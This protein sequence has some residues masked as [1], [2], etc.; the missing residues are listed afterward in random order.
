MTPQ[1]NYYRVTGYTAQGQ[2][3]FGG[4]NQ[5]VG[6]GATFNLDN[7]TPNT[8]LSWFPPLQ[9]LK[10][11]VA[12]SPFSSATLLNFESSDSS[13]MIT[14]EGNGLLN[15]QSAS[16]G[17]VVGH[18][19]F[20]GAGLLLQDIFAYISL[21]NSNP[22]NIEGAGIP[23]N[24]IA[25]FI[26][27]TPFSWTIDSVTIN[28][29]ATMAGTTANFGIY[30]LARNKL[31]D[32]GAMDTSSATGFVTN[33]I[34]PVTIPAGT[35]YFALSGTDD[36]QTVQVNSFYIST[37]YI[38]L[39]NQ[40]GVV[41]FGYATNLTVGGVMPSTLGTLTAFSSELSNYAAMIGAFFS[42]S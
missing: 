33:S 25:V 30:S 13:V 3:A 34:T 12:G 38:D 36:T 41:K 35:Y 14:D 27:D 18:G 29:I 1:N 26:F 40:V 4:N 22:G 17:S 7:W 20:I 6:S 8:V 19:G 31:V 28:V 9:N 5:Q 23:I 39:M 15:F 2:I 42:A 10:V 32:S 11:E 24:T 16:S 37:D 21:F